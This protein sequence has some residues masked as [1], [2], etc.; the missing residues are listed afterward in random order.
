MKFMHSLV[1]AFVIDTMSQPAE[2]IDGNKP[3]CKLEIKI[4]EF[5]KRIFYIPCSTNDDE[6][7]CNDLSQA[8]NA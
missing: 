1:G 2:M 5:F 4:S 6:N 3:H 8:A 7:F